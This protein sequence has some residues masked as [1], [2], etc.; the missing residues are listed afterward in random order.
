MLLQIRKKCDAL[1]GISAS[2]NA[3]PLSSPFDNGGENKRRTPH[4]IHERGEMVT[5]EAAKKV[6]VTYRATHGAGGM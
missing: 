3:F 6:G 1:A 4:S 2:S 5:L